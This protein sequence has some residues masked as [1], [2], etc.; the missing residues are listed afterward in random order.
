MIGKRHEYAVMAKYGK[1]LWWYRC[2]HDLTLKKI[3]EFSFPVNARILDAGC[4][5][6]GMLAHLQQNGY[7]NISGFDFSPD[8]IEFSE[9][10]AGLNV[11]LLDILHADKVYD[12]NSFDVIISNDILCLLKNND[13]KTA[14]NKLVSILRPGGVLIMNLPAGKIFSGTHD[15]A[16]GITK[17]Y[18]KKQLI[19]LAGKAVEIRQMLYWPF[20]LSPLIMFVRISQKFRL[21]LD[22]DMPVLSDVKMPASFMN[23]LFYRITSRENSF[24]K[25]K[26]WGSS[27]F[28][29]M[30]KL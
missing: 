28:I 14:F 4:G 24:M 2:L 27:V 8:A 16:V 22:K 7:Y 20:L 26:P 3:R 10:H 5:T 12:D 30:Q 13:D 18:S 1:E 19:E 29:V 15:I 23:R 25:T 6:G 9:K 17:R 21:M 11:Q